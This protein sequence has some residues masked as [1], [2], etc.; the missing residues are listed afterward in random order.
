MDKR[1][2]LFAILFTVLG[3]LTFQISINQIIGSTQKF[4]AFEFM[5]PIGGMFLGPWLGALSA[6][7]VRGL[8]VIIFQ[9]QLDFLTI[10]RFLP[11]IMAAVYFGLKTKKSA[12]IFPI[13]ILLFVL[14][15]IGRQ[16]WLYSAIWLIPFVASFF[17]QRLMLNSLGA[18]F[19][20]HAI[21]SVIF[22]YSFG[23]T[24]AIWLGLIPVVFIERGVFTIGIW[25]SCLGFNSVLNFLTNF[26]EISFLKPLVNKNYLISTNF[27][28]QY[29]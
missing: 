13:C 2:I 25:V 11:A 24:P 16:A 3:L 6:F 29:A 1:K 21:G 14:N 26:K 19:T 10:I 5:A 7:F 17:K 8:N 18:T 20:A 28:K 9:Q 15:P 22:L 4:T 23:L 27:F 12:I